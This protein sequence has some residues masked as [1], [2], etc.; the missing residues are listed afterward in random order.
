MLL[1]MND[2]SL[3]WQI[4]MSIREDEEGLDK[5]IPP[6]AQMPLLKTSNGFSTSRQVMYM[7]SIGSTGTFNL[8]YVSCFSTKIYVV[9]T[10]KN[11]PNETVLLSNQNICYN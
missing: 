9:G 1:K 8:E 6:L 2:F 7:F 3:K 5:M 4:L 11:R 10:Q